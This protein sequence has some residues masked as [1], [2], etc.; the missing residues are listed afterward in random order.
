VSVGRILFGDMW[1]KG[2][3]DMM[4]FI[5]CEQKP[6]LIPI[7]YIKRKSVRQNLRNRR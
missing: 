1:L 2:V 3:D 5:D 6:S 7:V 4:I